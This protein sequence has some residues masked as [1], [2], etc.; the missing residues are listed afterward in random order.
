MRRLT[1]LLSCLLMV[2]GAWGAPVAAQEAGEYQ[3]ASGVFQ[4]EFPYTVGSALNPKVDIDGLRWN[5]LRIA[6]KK[7]GRFDA[8]EQVEV[9]I[10]IGFENP[11]NKKFKA[12][13]VL[14]LEDTEGRK[15]GERM[16]LAEVK[17][18][19]DTAKVF[20]QKEQI[21]GGVLLETGKIYLFCEVQ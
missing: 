20:T 1:T 2:A 8:D 21:E 5:L 11:T 15:L 9:T 10:E 14:L 18:G 16:P 3:S 12:K 4:A 19:K 6:P 7:S 17:V 13:V